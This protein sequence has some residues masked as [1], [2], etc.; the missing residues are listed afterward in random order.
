MLVGW[1]IAGFGVGLSLPM[2]GVLML[3][4]AP[5]EQQGIYSS[6][7]QLCA[8]LCTSAA[9][10]AGGL[11]FSF[12]QADAPMRAFVGVYVIATALATT[13]WAS[14]NRTQASE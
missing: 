6:A 5:H 13:A 9:L 4:L 7:L 1:S 2:L 14:A 3:K 11:W 8:T 10:A 12:V